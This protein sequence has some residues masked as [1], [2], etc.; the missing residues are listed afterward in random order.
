M[1]LRVFFPPSRVWTAEVNFVSLGTVPFALQLISEVKRGRGWGEHQE[2]Q[3]S[4]STRQVSE[5]P[6]FF[7]L[8]CQPSVLIHLHRFMVFLILPT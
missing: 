4:W 6:D 2:T 8:L 1:L 7:N 5:D 3:V